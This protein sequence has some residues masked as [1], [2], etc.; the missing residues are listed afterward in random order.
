MMKYQISESSYSLINTDKDVVG[1]LMKHSFESFVFSVRTGEFN[2]AIAR[3]LGFNQKDA[4]RYFMCGLYHDVGKIGMSKYMID[5]PGRY[6]EDMRLEMKK[7]AE[8]GSL[9]LERTNAHPHYIETAKFHH[10]NY[11]G[12][13]Y[14]LPIGGES[15]PFHARMTRISD[16]ADAYLSKRS[17]K[18]GYR[19]AGLSEDMNGFSGTWYDP[20]IMKAFNKVHDRVISSSTSAAENMDQ[21]QYMFFLKNVYGINHTAEEFLFDLIKNA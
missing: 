10:A 16:S 4:E 12:T 7:H 20:L 19:V 8:G 17:Y 21:D 14:P 3:E 6:S 5:Y 13:G 18:E 1:L 2:F 11:D 9:L 15:I